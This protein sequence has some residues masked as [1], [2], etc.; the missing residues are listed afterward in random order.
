MRGSLQQGRGEGGAEE[1]ARGGAA[2]SG[3]AAHA[4]FP[5]W[6]ASWACWAGGWACRRPR[7]PGGSGTRCRGSRGRRWPAPRAPPRRSCSSCSG[8]LAAPARRGSAC[9]SLPASWGPS[10][11]APAGT[12][13]SGDQGGAGHCSA[14]FENTAPGKVAA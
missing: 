5:P 9:W 7:P 6:S 10:A 14:F 1:E 2:L 4:P 3:L 11:P 12:W 8:P 13:A